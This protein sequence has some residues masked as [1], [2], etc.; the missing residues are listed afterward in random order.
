MRKF[1]DF[2]PKTTAVN[3]HQLIS[4]AVGTYQPNPWGLYD[5]NGN[6]AEWTASD[7]QP[8]PLKEKKEEGNGEKKVVRGGSWRERPRYSTSAVRKAYEAWQRPM[9][10]GF[11]IIV[12]E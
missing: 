2:L 10:V 6:V 5:M 1:W 4:C 3:D 7:Y 12:E 11:R 9:N 8:Y